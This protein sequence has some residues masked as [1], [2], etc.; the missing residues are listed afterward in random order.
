M[1]ITS[2]RWITLTRLSW[3]GVCMALAA[4]SGPSR[5]KP[6]EIQ[7]VPVLQDV[8]ISWQANLGQVDFPLVVSARGD[9]V[10]LA[11]G[12]GVV[13]VLDAASGKEVWRLKLDQ[14]LSAGVGSDGQQLAVVTRNNELV[15][16]QDGK[17]QWR[18][19]LPAQSFTAPLVA[20]ARVFVLTADRSVLAFDGATGRQLWTQQRPG[21]PLVLKQAGVMLAVKNTLVVG[22]SGRLAGLD[23]S[24]GV[25]RWESAVATPRGTNDIERLV[26]LTAPFDRVGD[27]VCVRAFQASVGCVNA[28]RGQG[29]WTRPSVGENGVSGNETLVVAAL[30]NGVVQA[31][32]RSN[33]ERLWDTERL[34]YRVLSAPLVT[35]RGVL[36]ADN[37]GWLYLLS[38][39]DGA[40]LN[41]IKLEG[42]ALATAPVFAGG[43]YV[44][45]T[46]EG[47]VTGL[48]IP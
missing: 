6:T 10:A 3:V 17:V 7:G 9:R 40:L 13:A 24:T 14:P 26:D 36:L 44:V 41:R 12:Q 46:R 45:V 4:C 32:N 15:T 25:I 38:L 19:S 48:Q 11:S 42:E 8:R 33:G 31:F 43:R 21:E 47:R 20:G 16:L 18:K 5:P 37:G 22:L 2:S 34:K 27:V 28:E 30:S 35:P 29:V 39:T 1:N 23:P